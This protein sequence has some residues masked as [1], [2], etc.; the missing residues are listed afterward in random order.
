VN[1]IP[2]KGEC[3]VRILHGPLHN[4]ESRIEKDN[5]PLSIAHGREGTVLGNLERNA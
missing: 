5:S 3:G 4:A 1:L 2:W